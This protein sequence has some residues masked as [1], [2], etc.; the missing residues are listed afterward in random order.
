MSAAVI[1]AAGA[2]RRLGGVAKAGLRLADGRTFLRA[3]FE[4][5][6]RAGVRAWVVVAG[7][8]FAAETQ[9]LAASL[10]LPVVTNP[11]PERGMSSSVALGFGYLI[12]QFSRCEAGLLWPV[13]HP[14]VR[15]NSVRAVL[16]QAR[17]ECAVIPSYRGR[18]GHP[19]AFGRAL[20]PALAECTSAPQ[21]ARTVIAELDAADAERRA[22]D[23]SASARVLR[24]A[25]DDDGLVTDVDT[26]GALA[27]VAGSNAAMTADT[28]VER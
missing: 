2:G 27:A 21:G 15:A 25:L 9:A 26:P 13:D 14:R 1:L 23:A 12:E 24:P 6:Q 19:S 7:P 8:P 17:V 5:G 20:W 4:C 22:N 3:I 11:A 18:G 16:G 28:A 10:D